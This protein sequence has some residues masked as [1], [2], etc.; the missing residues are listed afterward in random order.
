M[1]LNPSAS[2]SASSSDRVH[3]VEEEAEGA[4]EPEG[5]D[6]IEDLVIK[7]DVRVKDLDGRAVHAADAPNEPDGADDP[8]D[9][10]SRS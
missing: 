1:M 8:Q 7:P 3:V 4:H 6:G 2:I 10:G 9:V 5:V